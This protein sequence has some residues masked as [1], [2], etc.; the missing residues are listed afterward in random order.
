MR[1]VATVDFET[2]IFG[3][4]MDRDGLEA[5][6]RGMEERRGGRKIGSHDLV[7][8]NTRMVGDVAYAS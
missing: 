8:L 7:D 6:I 2:L 1:A 3:R 5:F 4:G